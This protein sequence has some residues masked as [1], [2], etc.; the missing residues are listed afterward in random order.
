MML[1]EIYRP[2]RSQLQAAESLLLKELALKEGLLGELTRYIARMPGKRIRPALALLSASLPY[3]KKRGQRGVPGVNPKAVRLAVAVEMIHTATLLHDDVIDGA[4]LRRGLST[5]NAKWGDT[6]SVLSGDYLYSKAF[7]L[8]SE[9]KDH[10][11]LSLMS[12][13]AHT[14]CKGEVAQI[15]HQYDVNLSVPRYLKIIQWKTASL[16]GACAQAG[17]LLGG[18]S[19]SHAARLGDFGLNFGLAFQIMDDAQDLLG[20]EE[21]QGKS[22]GTDLGTGQMTLPLLY[23]RDVAGSQAR[24]ALAH[25]FNGNGNGVKG[26]PVSTKVDSDHG[27]ELCAHLKDQALKYQ[28]PAYCSATARGYLDRAKSA[29]RPFPSSAYKASLLSLTDFLLP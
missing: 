2:I 16:M 29:L 21:V 1:S 8:L 9:L 10:R 4:S 22:L 19:S 14:V 15:Q 23:L 3:S 17:A 20:S 26:Q 28:V 12:D 7:C 18:A 11:V 13:T 25:W 5:L 6:L 27:A 24:A